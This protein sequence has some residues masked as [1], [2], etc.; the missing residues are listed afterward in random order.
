MTLTP[1]TFR[2]ETSDGKDVEEY[3]LIDGYIE[4]RESKA[5]R[6]AG[7]WRTLTPA[8]VTAHVEK[9]TIVAQWLQQR[10]GWRG[11][12]RACVADQQYL[13]GEAATEKPHAA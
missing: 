10:L 12:L 11:L 4:V 1:M 2:I 8:E 13:Y 6:G 5:E 3:R 9:K 7:E